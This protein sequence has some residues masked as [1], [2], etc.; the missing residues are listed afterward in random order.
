MIRRT[1]ASRLK[2]AKSTLSQ[3]MESILNINRRRKTLPPDPSI[4]KDQVEALSEELKIL[5]KLAE[6]QAVLIRKYEMEL[7]KQPSS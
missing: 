7:T 4:K 3:T 2:Q 5:N 1:I 6:Q